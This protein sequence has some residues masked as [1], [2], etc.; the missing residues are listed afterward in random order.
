MKSKVNKL[1]L[2]QETLRQLT[3]EEL[4]TVA[5]GANTGITCH[6]ISICIICIPF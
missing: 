4:T 2:H 6:V 5:G 1:T 3:Q